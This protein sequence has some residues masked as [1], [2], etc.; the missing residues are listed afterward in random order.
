[1]TAVFRQSLSTHIYVFNIAGGS[2]PVKSVSYM[3][4]ESLAYGADWCRLTL[5]QLPT[6]DDAEVTPGHRE[7][8]AE[9]TTGDEYTEDRVGS[10]RILASCSFYDHA[11]HVWTI[12]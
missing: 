11:M 3:E 1:M 8:E 2:S 7:R 12:P 4:H 5:G 6:V 9:N 10:S